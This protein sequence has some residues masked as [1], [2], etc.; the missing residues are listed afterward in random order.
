MREFALLMALVGAMLIASPASAGSNHN[1]NS[2]TTN[3]DTTNT[4][5]VEGDE[6]SKRRA[7]SA[8]ALVIGTCQTGFSAQGP[9]G[10]A[11]AAASDSVCLLFT[12]SQMATE[13]GNTALAS[14]LLDRSVSILKWRTN[15]VR[16]FFQGLPLVGRYL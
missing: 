12:A 13:Q 6:D 1:H 2:T 5:T 15:K 8:A 10:G 11:S 9:M 16:V 14:E 3:N 7:H 4:T